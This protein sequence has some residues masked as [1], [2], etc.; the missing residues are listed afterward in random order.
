M[1]NLFAQRITNPLAPRLTPQSTPGA[2]SLFSDILQ[3]L[4]T[5]ALVAAAVIFFFVFILGGI[6]WIVSGG[7]KAKVEAAR[8]R[9]T[10][11]IVGIFLIFVLWAILTLLENFFGISLV[12]L[13]IGS[14]IVK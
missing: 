14:L 12:K 1:L 8:G 11:A 7:D 9:V 10:N 6:Q 5:L 3:R 13:D 4:I 2:V